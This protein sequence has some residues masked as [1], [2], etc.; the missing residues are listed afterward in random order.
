MGTDQPRAD[1]CNRKVKEWR[2]SKGK[3]G[4]KDYEFEIKRLRRLLLSYKGLQT[5]NTH[6]ILLQRSCPP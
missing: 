3:L 1:E 2:A 4:R 5:V 6:F